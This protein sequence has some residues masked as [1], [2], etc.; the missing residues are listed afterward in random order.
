MNT[1]SD[2]EEKSEIKREIRNARV[3][4][5]AVPDWR[6]QK[7][8]AVAWREK[9]ARPLRSRLRRLN[10]RLNELCPTQVRKKVRLWKPRPATC[11]DAR[12]ARMYDQTATPNLWQDN[13]GEDCANVE[14]GDEATR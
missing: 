5:A 3:M 7:P 4:L 6:C 1:T 8:W 10:L 2:I 14:V 9:I 12:I 11:A 13:G